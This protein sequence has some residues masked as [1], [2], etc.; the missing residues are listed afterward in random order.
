MKPRL[1]GQ[2]IAKRAI[3]RD[4]K[5]ALLHAGDEEDRSELVELLLKH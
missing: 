1:K 2:V 5:T 4:V 3:A